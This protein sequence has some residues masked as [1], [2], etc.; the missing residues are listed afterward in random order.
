MA[1][2]YRRM[3]TDQRLAV[4][5]GMWRYARQRIESAARWQYPE[6]DEQAVGREVSRRRLDASGVDAA[7]IAK[8]F[9]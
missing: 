2:L 8:C 4:V 9:G 5:H 6:W 1:D 7:V 3:T